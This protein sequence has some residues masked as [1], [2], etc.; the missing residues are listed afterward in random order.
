MVWLTFRFAKIQVFLLQRRK[1]KFLHRRCFAKFKHSCTQKIM[2]TFSLLGTQSF[3]FFIYLCM[4]V[5]TAVH[6]CIFFIDIKTI[7]GLQG[8]IE[9]LFIVLFLEILESNIQILW[10]FLCKEKRFVH[11][12]F[13][14]VSSVWFSCM[15]SFDIQY[16]ECLLVTIYVLQ[17]IHYLL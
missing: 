4:A 14:N 6:T 17:C 10:R 9:K 15:N 8:L 12:T 16:T 5:C 7:M 3:Y 2:Q 13:K 1:I 11:K